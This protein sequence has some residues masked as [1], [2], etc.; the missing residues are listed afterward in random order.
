MI[1][2]N[3]RMSAASPAPCPIAIRI[4]MLWVGMPATRA[5]GAGAAIAAL[6]PRAA[7]DEVVPHLLV[8]QHL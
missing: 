5:A 8:L 2:S 4:H 1:Q 6:E 3:S 7:V